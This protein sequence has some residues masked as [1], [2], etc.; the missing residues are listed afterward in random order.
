MLWNSR[1]LTT[2][3]G[4]IPELGIY[5]LFWPE[6]KVLQSARIIQMSAAKWEPGES[7]F[8][9]KPFMLRATFAPLPNQQWNGFWLHMWRRK[10]RS[11]MPSLPP[12][13]GSHIQFRVFGAPQTSIPYKYLLNTYSVLGTAQWTSQ[14]SKPNPRETMTQPNVPKSVTPSRTESLS[15]MV[16]PTPKPRGR[17]WLYSCLRSW[18]VVCIGW[19]PPRSTVLLSIP[20][21]CWLPPGKVPTH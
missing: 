6:T 1:T 19:C 17:D 10:A 21:L 2:S 11:H 9:F 14:M 5:E 7:Q 18:E 16:S 20:H 4:T 3:P 12:A 8:S 15:W 13:P